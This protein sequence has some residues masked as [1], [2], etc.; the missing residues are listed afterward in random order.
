MPGTT[1]NLRY[2]WLSPTGEFIECNYW[3]HYETA[4]RI[5]KQVF[6]VDEV[7]FEHIFEEEDKLYEIGW[8]KISRSVFGMREWYFCGRKIWS[9]EQYNFLKPYIDTDNL[10]FGSKCMVEVYEGE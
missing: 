3:E 4:D 9:A 2:G 7:P 6:H 5:Y 1:G 10:S 8:I